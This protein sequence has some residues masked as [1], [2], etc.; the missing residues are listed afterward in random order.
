MPATAIDIGT[1]SI[2]AISG[3]TG[4]QPAINRAVEISNLAGISVPKDNNQAGKLQEI[5]VQLFN[6]HKLPKTDIY[7]S[8]PE[9]IVATK[10]INL[11]PLSSAELASAI[12]WQA[13]QH[14]PIPL[15]Q[16]SLEYQILYKPPAK[17][18]DESMK[19]LLVGT[20]KSFVEMYV[21][22]F[23][24]LGIQPLIL[25]TQIFSVMRALGFVPE[26]PTT[27]IVNMGANN[28][29]L[30][31][32]NKTQIEIATN[33][34]GGGALFTKTIQQSISNLTLE[35][36]EEYKIAYGLLKDQLQ[37]KIS[38]TILPALD[39]I[40]QEVVKTLRFYNNEQPDTPITRIVLTGGS[41]QMPGIIEYF[42][43]LTGTETLLASPFAAASGNI[44]ENNHQAFIVCMGLMMRQDK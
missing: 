31:V 4:K 8:L 11:P 42:T 10:V 27:M 22:L 39:S 25:E 40:G 44:P 37:G 13:E 14:I 33:K 32:V 12:D 24:N 2:K 43:Q 26:D 30:A 21:D 9:E 38:E 6:D 29:Q 34:K 18:K 17:A 23:Y 7:L 19:V 20:R 3:K 41:A 35:Q 5:V 15:D 16:L 1:H 36:A 28:T